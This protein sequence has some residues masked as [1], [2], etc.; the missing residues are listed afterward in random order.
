MRVYVV[1]YIKHGYHNLVYGVYEDKDDAK[2]CSAYLKITEGLASEVYKFEV[3]KS[4]KGR[5]LTDD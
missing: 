5:V 1:T 4:T 2:R 3:R